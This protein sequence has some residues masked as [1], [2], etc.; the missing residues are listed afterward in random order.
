MSACRELQMRIWHVQNFKELG[1]T[2]NHVT[3]KDC[4]LVHFKAATSTCWAGFL[5][6]QHVRD[7]AEHTPTSLARLE[8]ARKRFRAWFAIYAIQKTSWEGCLDT[9]SGIRA[10]SAFQ[11]FTC[12]CQA[13]TCT[14]HDLEVLLCIGD[15]MLGA[16]N[17]IHTACEDVMQQPR[18][19]KMLAGAN[20]KWSLRLGNIKAFHSGSSSLWGALNIWFQDMALQITAQPH[21][22]S[23]RT[24]AWS[25][26]SNSPMIMQM[27]LLSRQADHLLILSLHGCTPSTCWRSVLFWKGAHIIRQ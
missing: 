20:K 5:E 3:D 2:Y 4:C 10:Y 21:L 1:S 6:W 22:G 12:Q 27:P 24:A 15:I 9:I 23:G 26:S 8:G 14:Y 17:R 11:A 7:Q 13:L 25:A 19:V 18:R 16:F